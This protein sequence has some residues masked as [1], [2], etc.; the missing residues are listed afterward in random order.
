MEFRRLMEKI[1]KRFLDSL[2]QYEVYGYLKKWW[3]IGY[4]NLQGWERRSSGKFTISLFLLCKRWHWTFSL[5][6]TIFP[7]DGWGISKLKMVFWRQFN[8]FI[9]LLNS[10]FDFIF[11]L[12]SH[13]FS[14]QVIKTCWKSPQLNRRFLSFFGK[15]EF[16]ALILSVFNEKTC[17][18]ACEKNKKPS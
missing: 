6:H 17:F 18:L 1:K 2:L 9:C 4:K 15:N 16:G 11:L 3:W 10:I 7:R 12:F 5:F 14:F 8:I 13:R